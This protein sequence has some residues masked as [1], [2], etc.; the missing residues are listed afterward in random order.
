MN[1]KSPTLFISNKVGHTKYE[2]EVDIKVPHHQVHDRD[3]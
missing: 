2:N 1:K 3:L